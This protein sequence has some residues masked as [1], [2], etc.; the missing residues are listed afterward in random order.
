VV[1]PRRPPTPRAGRHWGVVG[2]SPTSEH[3]LTHSRSSSS[4][5]L[6]NDPSAGSPTETLFDFSFL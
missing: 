6:D 5:G 4:M 2:T 3:R 1:H